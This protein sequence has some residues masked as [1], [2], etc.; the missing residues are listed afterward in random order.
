MKK[1]KITIFIIIFLVIF[2]AASFLFYSF[3]IIKE[4]HLLPAD[5]HISDKQIGF[6]LDKDKFHF[7]IVPKGA[8]SSTRYITVTNKWN[9]DIDVLITGEGELASWV[10][11]K[12]NKGDEEI[13]VSRITLKPSESKK[14]TVFLVPPKDIEIGFYEGTIKITLKKK[15]FFN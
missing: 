14:I 11:S 8:R 6:N 7:G 12:I 3:Y 13:I 5:V 10:Y 2:L 15:H 9:Y 1:F 4:V